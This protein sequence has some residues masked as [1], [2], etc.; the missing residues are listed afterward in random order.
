MFVG[1]GIL[2]VAV[3]I[4][5]TVIIIN[6]KKVSEITEFNTDKNYSDE[7]GIHYGGSFNEFITNPYD[8]ET[9]ESQKENDFQTKEDAESFLKEEHAKI[10]SIREAQ[11]DV[12]EAQREA[13][14]LDG[15]ME[16][17][18]TVPSGTELPA[19]E[20]KTTNENGETEIV[21]SGDWKV[22]MDGYEKHQVVCDAI[23]MGEAEDIASQIGGKV[24]SCEGGT[25]IIEITK[26]VDELLAELEKQGSDLK[27]YRKYIF[28]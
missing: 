11:K 25:A 13:A 2:I 17:D 4:I 10:E 16:Q 18:G 26:D 15:F 9:E 21:I 1:I 20:A 14:N 6:R 3:I 7:M 23:H 5:V 22:Q 28:K 27:L 12:N 8:Q 24:L 19:E